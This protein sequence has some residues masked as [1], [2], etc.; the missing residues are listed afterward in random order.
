M[1]KRGGKERY[2]DVFDAHWFLHESN[3][4]EN[5]KQLT[6]YIQNIRKKLNEVGYQDTPIWIGEMA[7]YSGS[8]FIA[9]REGAIKRNKPYISEKQHAGELIKLYVHTISLGVSKMFWVRLIEWNGY[10]RMYGYFDNTGLINNP[11]NDGE[12]HKKLAYYSYKKLAE[13]LKGVDIR[14]IEVLNLGKDVYAYKLIK[15]GHPIYFMWA[16]L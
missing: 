12:S 4:T 11:I 1:N 6:D 14:T 16:D 13:I 8:P 2:F 5:F 7:S 10:N 3:Y 9:T 15:N